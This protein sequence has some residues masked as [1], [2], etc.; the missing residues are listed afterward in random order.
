MGWDRF[1]SQLDSALLPS[2]RGL[3]WSVFV[4]NTLMVIA[5]LAVATALIVILRKLRLPT[6]EDLVRASRQ[7]KASEIRYRELFD[8]VTNGIWQVDM[9]G[10]TVLAN[11]AMAKM[12]GTSL[13]ELLQSNLLNF[14]PKE[15]T[16][17][18]GE[19]R[20][21][22]LKGI[23]E[24]HEFT[25]I[26]PDGST[27]NALISS[28]P[29]MDDAGNITGVLGIFTDLTEK[30][31]IL[32]K[33]EI[34]NKKLEARVEERTLELSE[35]NK[36]LSEELQRRELTN[37]QLNETKTY[38]DVIFNATYSGIII[39]D[40]TGVISGV[41]LAVE[42]MFGYRKAELIGKHVNMLVPESFRGEHSEFINNSGLSSSP[43]ML[44]SGI[45]LRAVR[46]YNAEF[47]VD[48]ALSCIAHSDSHH[49][50]A[51]V[52]DMT[53]IN[54][55]EDELQQVNKKLLKTVYLLK[56]K[57]NLARM[58]NEYSEMLQACQEYFEYVPIVKSFS[59]LLFSG[60]NVQIYFG[61]KEDV[62]YNLDPEHEG[63]VLTS[64]CMAFKFCKI[65]PLNIRE[66]EIACKHQPDHKNRIC[67]PL[68]S[69]RKPLGL[70]TMELEDEVYK[71]IVEQEDQ[72]YHQFLQ[73]FSVRTSILLANLKLLK[74][75]EEL[76]LKDELTGLY[77]RR[78][79]NE[80]LKKETSLSLRDKLP[81]TL[82]MLDIDH[83]KT[84]NDQY[85]HAMGDDV[86]VQVSS[87]IESCMR[88]T[89][90]VVRFG[91]EEF[92]VIMHDANEF[93]AKEKALEIHRAIAIKVV[94]PM[95]VTVSIGIAEKEYDDTDGDLLDK[96]D[97]AL[98]RA[99]ENGRNQTCCISQLNLPPSRP[100][101]QQSLV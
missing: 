69:K 71:M 68:I 13:E 64:D 22:R 27:V 52:R 4:P 3:F 5:Y 62:L 60:K 48:I 92:I 10:Q 89:D 53:E 9:S 51:M 34:S 54:M 99:K 1:L 63:L 93:N 44:G 96:V 38:L 19:Y 85:G 74:E 88:E 7:L 31:K 25:F 26:R 39:T 78:F 23:K 6:T 24:T 101:D 29:V 47:P 91:G 14:I 100:P 87:T 84:F 75:K 36:R 97:K 90:T 72:D 86:L 46:R 11:S 42:S 37:A 73:A 43:K 33:L 50:M 66:R 21:R 80:I 40:K 17:I 28:T 55:A 61:E 56:T 81:L 35:T 2:V 12:V 77:N 32:Q 18:L 8:A 70:I 15:I 41:N 98:Y 49:Y 65:Y 20:S 95:V 67:I 57:T 94:A 58:I 79:M 59:R 16:D 30:K 82:L 83:F 76:A 45:R